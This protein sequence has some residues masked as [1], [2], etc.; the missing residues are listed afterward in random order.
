MNINQLKEYPQNEHF[1]IEHGPLIQAALEKYQP[2]VSELNFTEMF[3]WRVVRD[4]RISRHRGNI[5]VEIE[6][7]NTHYFFPPIGESEIQQTIQDLLRNCDRQGKCAQ[8]FAATKDIIEKYPGLK[9]EFAVE[10]DRKEWD[11]V[12]LRD[13]LVELKGRKYDGKRNQINKFNNNYP[14]HEIAAIEGKVIGEC[15]EFQDKWCGM[16]P[17][18]DDIS[19]FN[20][21][22][23]VMEVLKN[24]EKLP[25]IGAAMKIKGNVEGFTIAG[26]LNNNTAVVHIEKANH[27][28]KGIYQAINQMFCARFL[29]GFQFINRE[30]DLDNEGL[31]KAKLS[32]YPHHMVE[33]FIIKTK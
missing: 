20:E 8:I 14:E 31:R 25:V 32:Y 3:A 15:I 22:N 11:Y 16:K 4:R 10:E 9:E 29:A 26:R 13:D 17:C 27:E 18:K 1:G 5:C 33:K 6:R 24:Y 30:Q 19:L 23:A 21:N 7:D 28:F 2:E 12:Y